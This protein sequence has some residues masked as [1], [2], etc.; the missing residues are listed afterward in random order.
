LL[1]FFGSTLTRNTLQALGAGVLVSVLGFICFALA[2]QPP[3]VGDV[4]LWRGNLVRFIGAP[5]MILAVL[6]L[7]YGNY[8]RLQLDLRTWF[9]NGL[10]LLVALTSVAATTTAIYHR[11]W[12][13][14]MP[15]EPTHNFH[16]SYYATRH[17]QFPA[18]PK[19]QATLANVALLLP[20]GRLWLRHRPVKPERHSIPKP[21]GFWRSDM[22][23]GSNWRA[24]AAADTSCFAIQ[25]DGSL[26][27]VSSNESSVAPGL[28]PHQVDPG[29]D[30]K[31]IS[32][33]GEHFTA[34]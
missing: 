7:A 30:W 1:S 3:N 18:V 5:I 33:G 28:V 34:L 16:S 22:L 32:A 19:L 27:Q 12:E 11:F 31:S 26:W 9:Q 14:W 21:N 15:L 8:K 24:V 4:V 23:P 10:T 17:H 13:A 25:A 6:T 2:V 20:D 29:R